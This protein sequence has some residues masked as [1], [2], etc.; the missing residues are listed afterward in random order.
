MAVEKFYDAGVFYNGWNLTGQSNQVVLTR[1]AAM[2]DATV[3]G[4]TTRINA[5][6]LDEINVNVNGLWCVDA[7]A[8]A[9]GPDPGLYGRIGAAGAALTLYPK[10]VDLGIAYM[11]PAVE[12][13]FNIFGDFGTL[14]PFAATYAF[15]HYNGVPKM[16]ARGYIGLQA[17][18]RTATTGNGTGK[19]YV[20]G[21]TSLQ[22]LVFCVHVI[23]TDSTSLTFV[24]QSDDNA[25]FTT[26][27]TR[28]TSGVL[29]G[30]SGGQTYYS[31]LQGPLTDDYYRV[32]W[33][34]VGGTT[35]TAL[36]TFGVYEPKGLA[37]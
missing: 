23:A 36:A 13:T 1:T 12:G 28:I 8:L 26:P 18:A 34:R 20:G 5:A 21:I 4:N 15:A 29:A 33:T 35:F 25:G 2:L 3:F 10:N 31:H 14:A 22:Y 19:Q 32:T 16:Q 17:T 11:F 6:G 9:G 30:G 27:T 37:A 24:L 7:T